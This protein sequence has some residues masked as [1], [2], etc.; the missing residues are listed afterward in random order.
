MEEKNRQSKDFN[1]VRN[2]QT[3]M[4]VSYPRYNKIFGKCKKCKHELD[5]T[6]PEDFNKYECFSEKKGK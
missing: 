2:I 1:E 5:C 4:D 6:L 3:T